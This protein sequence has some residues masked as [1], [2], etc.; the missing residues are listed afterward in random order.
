MDDR[1]AAERTGRVE[2]LLGRVEDLQDGSAREIAT[3]AVAALVELYGEGIAR[4]VDRLGAAERAG[5][6]KDELVAHLLMVHDLHPD[7][8]E[9][10]VNQA[11]ASVRPYLESHGGD[12]ELLA[13]EDGKARLRLD[14]SCSG[15]PSSTETLRLAVEDSIRRQAPE[16]ESI[17]AEGADPTAPGPQL[18]QIE[19]VQ[20][21]ADNGDG[22]E[23]WTPVGG[24]P[25]L[26]DGGT[27]T[28]EVSGERL[29][30]AAVGA[31]RYAYK[32]R[33]PACD[34]SLE[35][36]EL[37]GAELRCPGC[38]RSYDVTRAG[39]CL[40]AP[41]LHLDPVPLLVG[42]SG[43]ARVAMGSVA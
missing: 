22:P 30:F 25:E 42:D 4:I 29:L 17:E 38:G 21:P 12:V 10:R 27:L 13:I 6:A 24:L 37:G 3:D 35:H 11:L 34:G 31:N 36:A 16:I 40:D 7:P 8:L 26:D 39:R 19:N 15:C 2:A 23:R 32:P 18:L 20:P 43:I 9:A 14:G 1:E 28:R 5:L 33:C 41:Q